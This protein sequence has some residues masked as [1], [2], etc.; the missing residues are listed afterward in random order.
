MMNKRRQTSASQLHAF[1]TSAEPVILV[2]IFRNW[3]RNS[4]H[5]RMNTYE[6]LKF[7]EEIWQRKN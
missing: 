3:P 7:I 5:E 1:V 4:H 6:E 2:R